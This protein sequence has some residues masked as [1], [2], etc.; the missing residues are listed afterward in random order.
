MKTDRE[1]F[2]RDFLGNKISIVRDLRLYEW[3]FLK[4]KDSYL[5]MNK[6]NIL[7]KKIFNKNE[8]W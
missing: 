1:N 2:K 5:P 4:Y 3:V 7:R 6:G 8:R